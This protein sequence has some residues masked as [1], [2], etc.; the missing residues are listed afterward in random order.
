MDDG[1]KKL[2]AKKTKMMML[3][4]LIQE[5]IIQKFGYKIAFTINTYC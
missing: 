2:G 3:N 4:Q 5:K 1:F